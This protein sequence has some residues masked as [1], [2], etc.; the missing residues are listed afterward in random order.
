MVMRRYAERTAVPADRSKSEIERILSRYGATGFA[1]MT[2]AKRA[3]VAFQAHMRNIRFI[4]P[5]PSVSDMTRTPKGK[6]RRGKAAEDAHSQEMRRRWRALALSIKAKLETV[7]S[8]IAEFETEFMPYVV[9][10]NGKTVAENVGPQIDAA[11]KTG[12]MPKLLE[13]LG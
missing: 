2:D 6:T 7:Q 3:A 9:L 1:Y 10:P 4:L 8:G 12:K 5:L 11:Y 13:A